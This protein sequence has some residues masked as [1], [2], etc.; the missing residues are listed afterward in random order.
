MKLQDFNWGQQAAFTL[1]TESSGYRSTC[2]EKHY[3][4][5]FKLRMGNVW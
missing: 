4:G 1:N 3:A 2:P 5:F